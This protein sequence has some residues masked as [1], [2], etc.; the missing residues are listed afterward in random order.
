METVKTCDLSEDRCMS[1]VRWGS[2]YLFTYYLPG[3]CYPKFIC[4]PK[5]NFAASKLL[6][7]L[8]VVL[9]KFAFSSQGTPY[10]A[11]SGTKQFYISKWCSSKQHCDKV[12][13]NLTG[14]CDRISYNDWQCVDCCHGDKCNFFV[15]VSL[16]KSSQ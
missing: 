4:C 2:E 7:A 6:C 5:Q 14:K 16:A 9:T 13:A 3:A 11:P 15:T 1:V 12:K 8:T 10:W